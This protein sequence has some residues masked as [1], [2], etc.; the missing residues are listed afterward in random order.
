[1]GLGKVKQKSQNLGLM[2]WVTVSAILLCLFA[3]SAYDNAHKYERSRAA[4]SEK[5]SRYAEC[6]VGDSLIFNSKCIKQVTKPNYDETTNYYD[7]KA[8]QDMAKWALLMLVV[9]SVGVVYVALTLREAQQTNQSFKLSS[10]RQ[11][12]AY[13]NVFVT[14][15]TRVPLLGVTQFPHKTE[16]KLS[17][18]IKNF[19][20]TPAYKISIWSN[21]KFMK[22]EDVTKAWIDSLE[23]FEGSMYICPNSE[24]GNV[25]VVQDV[26]FDGSADKR[27]TLCVSIK[28]IDAF[29][30]VQYFRSAWYASNLNEWLDAVENGKVIGLDFG[31]IESFTEAT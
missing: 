3:W 9:T 5:Q 14:K 12:R 11:L 30:N 24:A 13:L 4:A 28:Y 17:I 31:R 15:A 18:R 26:I 2:F 7:L 1:M 6:F 16:V 25:E 21:I 8:Q 19:G 29:D 27:I 20:Q 10:Q 22:I 23:D